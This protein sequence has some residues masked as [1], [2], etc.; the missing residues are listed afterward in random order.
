MEAELG[1]SGAYVDGIYVCPHHPDKGFEGERP[2][3]K[4][5]CECRKPKAG[6]LY[7]AAADF[8]LDLGKSVMIGDSPAD[9]EAGRYAGVLESM[10]LALPEIGL[11]ECV[12][13]VLEK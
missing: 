12:R 8:N 9:V 5:D 4:C 13:K 1:K 7:Q 11:N 6:L 2:E 3:Y 10:C